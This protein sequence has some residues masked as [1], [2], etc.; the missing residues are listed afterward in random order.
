MPRKAAPPSRWP[1]WTCDVPVET[2]YDVNEDVKREVLAKTDLVEVIGAVTALK[3]IGTSWKGLCPFHGEKTPSFHV[4]P[5]KGFYYCFGCGAKGDAISFV[6]ETERLDFVEA[7]A[8]LARRAGIRLPERRTGTRTDRAKEVS[9]AEALAAAARFFREQLSQSQQALAFLAKR[10]LTPEKAVTFGIGAAPDSWD[11]LKTNLTRKFGE[12]VLIEAGLVQRH[13]DTGRIYDRFRNRLTFELTDSRGD[14]AGF[15]ARAFGDEPPKYLN[16]PETPRFS[17]GKLLYGLAGAREGIRKSGRVILVEGYFDQIAFSE[18][19][20]GEAVASMGTS[21]TSH[22]ADLLSRLGTEV[23]VAYDGDPPGL[24]A[25]EK[26]FALLLERDTRIRHLILPFGHDPDSYLRAFGKDALKEAVAGSR[27]L[28]ESLAASVVAAGQVPEARAARIRETAD[29][30]RRTSNAVLRY[31]L[32][33][34]LAKALS[35]PLRLLDASALAKPG[36]AMGKGPEPVLDAK[37][38]ESEE[39]VLRALLLSWPEGAAL[40]KGIPLDLFSHPVAREVFASMK[41]LDEGGPPLD[42]SEWTTHLGKAAER[43]TLRLVLSTP[44]GHT[45]RER[46]LDL[47][48]LHKSLVSLKIRSLEQKGKELQAEI[49]ALG[50]PGLPGDTVRTRGLELL[51]E[52]QR[53]SE[54]IRVLKQ[55]LRRPSACD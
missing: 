12:A 31:E 45:P 5:E 7:V 40:V 13:Q 26:A 25:S 42:F 39:T 17:K 18:A 38:P 32:L 52:K 23:I 19:G 30:L 21:L 53:L 47:G 33:N 11:S 9:T 49:Q 1:S 27:S 44:E 37:V 15:A 35:I 2:H 43:L 36:T 8:Y 4:H 28:I 16:S 3:K 46:E 34:G 51:E 20:L 14:L 29:V 24:A 48:R 54:E 22:Q 41:N 55:E 50:P 6:R 10:G